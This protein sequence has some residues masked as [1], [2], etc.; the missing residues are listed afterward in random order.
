[1]VELE[2]VVDGKTYWTREATGVRYVVKDVDAFGYKKIAKAHN[3]GDPVEAMECL[4]QVVAKSIG[5]P[6]DVVFGTEEVQG[7]DVLEVATV[8]SLATKHVGAV[9]KSTPP[10]SAPAGETQKV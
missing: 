4:A 5:A 7:F 8:I 2:E 3:S 6:L 1:M 9:E 10:F